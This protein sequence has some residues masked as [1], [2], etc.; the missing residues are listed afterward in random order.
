MDD[1]VRERLLKVLRLAQQGVGG[2]KANAEALLAKL[3]NKH[4]L[5]R[6]AIETDFGA[7]RHTIWLD[8]RDARER[9]I[10]SQLMVRFVGRTRR[11]FTSPAVPRKIG[12][13]ASSSEAIAMKLA[14]EVYQ[15]AW[16]KALDD[17]VL[18]FVYKHDL[19]D[20]TPSDEPI[21]ADDKERAEHMR[22]IR[23]AEGL[24]AV[25]PPMPQ[26]SAGVG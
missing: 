16:R 25:R 15:P 7:E 24:E 22:A 1:T 2:E 18:A 23:L 21:S 8:G 4:G 20:P 13:E 3:L 17:L 5:T 14:W 26:L 10:L 9:Q 11:L 6:D 12:C 19:F